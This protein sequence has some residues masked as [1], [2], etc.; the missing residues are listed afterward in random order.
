VFFSD[1]FSHFSVTYTIRVKIGTHR[2][3]PTSTCKPKL[4]K[5]QIKHF[6]AAFFTYKIVFIYLVIYLFI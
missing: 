5:F 2:F 6:A 3:C 4:D 1:T